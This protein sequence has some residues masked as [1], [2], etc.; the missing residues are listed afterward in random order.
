MTLREDAAALAPDLVALRRR[1]HQIPEIGLHLPKTQQAVLEALDG[2][3]L[4]ISVGDKLSSV[5]AVLRGGRPGGP[6][7][8]LRGDMDALPVTERTGEEFASRHEGAM[9]ACGHDLHTAGL[10][11]AARLLSARAAELPGDVVFMFQPGEEGYDGARHM[12]DEGVLE[13]AGRP[14]DAA[15]GIHV[16]SS[17]TRAG[18]FTGRPGPLMAASAGL[19]VRV[20]GAGGHGSTPYRALDPVPVAC[21]M[22]TALQAMVT[23][24][25]NVFDPV[26]V[27]VGRFH[28][29]TRR[30]IIPEDAV[31]EA[32]V[33]A[34]ST[35]T[36]ERLS[37]YTVRLCQDIATAHGL[38]ADVVFAGE[39]PVTVNDPDEHEFVAATV[40][41]VFG[42]D[43]FE[44][45]EHPMTGSEDFSR[46][47]E[48]VPGAYVF[49]GATVGDDPENA[50]TNHSPLARFDDSVLPDGAALLAELAVR[51]LTALAKA[52]E[53]GQDRALVTPRSSSE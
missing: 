16:T 23:R 49:L 1:L 33:R 30:N 39:Y 6:V 14:V 9:H 43:R 53:A 31:F 5:T 40:R 41:E 28:A 15:Y 52:R 21:E 38:R 42:E 36:M 34:F 29:G 11:G 4:E 10:V 17:K 27:T 46:V 8:L 50:P 45:M 25:F 22:V 47:L 51:K 19:T 20:V 44:L 24:R 48:R 32:T 2:L 12:I 3:P 26:V 18:V 37:E 7:V 13:A 35:E